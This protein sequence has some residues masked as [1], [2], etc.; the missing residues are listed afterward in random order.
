MTAKRGR[1]KKETGISL[2]VILETSLEV[3]EKTGP[4]GFS[5]R[6]LATHLKITPMAIY[7]YFPNRAALIKEL[8]DR[9]YSQVTEDFESAQDNA[10]HKI[11]QLLTSYYQTGLRYPNLTLAVFSTPE[12]FSAKVKRITFL[13][14]KLL[15][16]TKL[17]PQRRQ[18][19]LEILVDF[20]HGSFLATATVSR[21]NP[22]LA[23]KQGERYHQQLEELLNQI[24]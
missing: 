18:M 23:K 22:R 7:H 2:D 10:R 1:P 11:K 6:T 3:L 13:L 24:F 4:Q 19:W 12:A 16:A 8:S 9:V 5:M 21:S 17:I 20:T 14:D 15:K